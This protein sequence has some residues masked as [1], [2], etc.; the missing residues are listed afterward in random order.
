MQPLASSRSCPDHF[1]LLSLAEGQLSEE[2]STAI[3]AHVEDCPHCDAKL[4]QIEDASDPLIQALVSL[5]ATE[6]DEPTFRRLQAELLA[7]P[8]PFEGERS[9]TNGPGSTEQW[10]DEELAARYPVMQLPFQLGNYDLLEQI[11]AGSH[12]AV[13]RARH[14]RLER[15]VAVK[16]LMRA[17]SHSVDEFLHEMRVVGKLDHPNIIRATDAGEHEGVYFLVMEFVPGLDVSSL[18]RRTG[19]LPIAE[20][21]EIARQCALGLDVAHRSQLVHRD[22]KTSNLLF[23]HRGQVKI[24]DLGLATIS[25]ATHSVGSGQPA[26][27]H[28]RGTADYMAPEQWRASDAVSGKADLYSL[29][30]TLFKL[31]AGNPPFRPLPADRA[32]L[33]EAHL[34]SDPPSLSTRR[35]GVPPELERLVGRLLAKDPVDRPKTAREVASL[36]EPFASTSD[37]PG[38]LKEHCPELAREVTEEPP[39][40]LVRRQRPPVDR[41]RRVAL[42]SVLAV[43]FF[44]FVAANGWL[45]PNRMPVDTETWRRLSPARPA[46]L[47]QTAESETSFEQRDDGT[48]VL[49]SSDVALLHFGR[50]LNGAYRW[51]TELKRESWNSFAGLFFSLRKSGEEDFTYQTIEI[52]E[53]ENDSSGFITFLWRSYDTG[54]GVVI[55][56]AEKTWKKRDASGKHLLEVVIGRSGFPELACDG[57]RLAPSTWTKSKHAR[58]FVVANVDQLASLFSGR[59]GVVQESGETVVGDSKL[60]YLPD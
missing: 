41:R 35:N 28:P 60:I 38:L 40:P 32:S 58:D 5:P 9:F 25:S 57:E 47:N 19:P 55:D 29:G 14:R 3:S 51:K 12:G 22:I 30:C 37:L 45:F 42:F 48:L 39:E 54:T 43:A 27:S 49:R 26:E 7:N 24:L 1:M 18:L 56:L 23:T 36:L 8:L 46:L 33:Q 2:E 6:D 4:E 10:P 20:A 59:I 52:H 50:P 44:G 11:G 31:L 53:P 17:S 21:C 15:E 34:Q 13:F 16:L